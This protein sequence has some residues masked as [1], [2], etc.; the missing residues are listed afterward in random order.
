VGA[1]APIPLQPEDRAILDLE[2]DTVAGHTCKVVLLAAPAPG[3]EALRRS[4]A[5]RMDGAPELARRLADAGGGPA[6]VADE[7]FDVA[8]HV[9]ASPSG[10]ALDPD[11]LREEVA[12]LF[13][14]RLDRSRPLWRIDVAPLAD[15]GQALI[16]RTHHALADGTTAMRLAQ[17]LLWDEPPRAAPG[18]R[19]PHDDAARRRRLRGFLR[20]EV[21]PPG[22]PS[23]FDGPV[24]TRREVAFAALPLGSLHDAARSA[25]GATVNDALLSAVAG[26]VRHWLQERHGDLGALRL[27]VPVSLHGE[28]DGAANRDSFF[29]IDVPLDEPSPLERLRAVHAATAERKDDRDAETLDEVMRGLGRLSPA[30]RGLAARIEASPRAFAVAV[31]NVAGPRSPVSVLGAPVRGLY[32]LAEIG[33]R[34]ALRVAAVS[35]AGT[36]HLGVVADPDLV[37]EPQVLADGAVAEARFLIDAA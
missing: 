11:G 9:V 15:G 27:R 24:G 28:G 17:A 3:L 2:G 32:T 21:G 29:S 26:G 22:R 7:R 36:L 13:A 23:P 37:G 16:W 14:Q 8:D 5:A 25:C 33:R 30:L 6:W 18:P 31:S 35:A 34:H 4:V 12:A 10:T 1:A 19:A 20:R